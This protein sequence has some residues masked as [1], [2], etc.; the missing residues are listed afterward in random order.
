MI[1]ISEKKI[2]TRFAK[3]RGRIALSEKSIEAIREGT[4]KKR[5]CHRMRK[6]SRNPSCE[7]NT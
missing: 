3:A 1:D 2:V 6:N 5:R 7:E 4:V